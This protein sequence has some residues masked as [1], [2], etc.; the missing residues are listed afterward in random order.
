MARKFNSQVKEAS[1]TSESK[2]NSSSS[3]AGA[4]NNCLN[5]SEYFRSSA[6]KEADKRVSRLLTIKIHIEISDNFTG[7]RRQTLIYQLCP[8]G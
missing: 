5:I 4:T 1:I 2:T 3:N 8:E 7:I 6:K